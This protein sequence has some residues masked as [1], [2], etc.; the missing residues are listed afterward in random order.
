MITITLLMEKGGV[1]KTTLATTIAAGLAIQG[2]R[3]LIIDA[4]GQGHATRILGAKLGPGLYDTLVREA[5]WR[6]TLKV[7]NPERYGIE[8]KGTL[9][10]LP[11][12]H[13]TMLIPGAIEDAFLLHNR[14]QELANVFDAVIIDTSPTPSLLNASVLFASDYVMIP[15]KME[16]LSLQSLK[17]SMRTIENFSKQRSLRGESPVTVLG[18]VPTAYRANTTEHTANLDMLTKTYGG[19]VMPPIH[20]RIIWSEASVNQKSIFAYAQTSRATDE[21]WQVVDVVSE[22]VNG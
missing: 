15:S 11:G 19:L 9:A 7:V 8:A 10:L 17:S 20:D 3:V 5:D 16:F 14:I 12:N 2:K 18:I 22:V 13:E 21:A 1:G 4:D 6:D